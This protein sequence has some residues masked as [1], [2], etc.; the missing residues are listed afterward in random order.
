[1]R[2]FKGSLPHYLEM[3]PTGDR[4]LVLVE[5]VLASSVETGLEWETL[6]SFPCSL[7]PLSV[8]S[9]PLLAWVSDKASRRATSQQIRSDA[10]RKEEKTIELNLQLYCLYCYREWSK[11]LPDRDNSHSPAKIGLYWFWDWYE[12][13]WKYKIRFVFTT[14]KKCN[15]IS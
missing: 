6:E 9:S 4:A 5:W 1:M 14:S 15:C 7:C 13:E 8:Q 2:S 3:W 11:P 12:L 10:H